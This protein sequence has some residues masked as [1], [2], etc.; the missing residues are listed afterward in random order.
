MPRLLEYLR[1]SEIFRDA[2]LLDEACQLTK[3]FMASLKTSKANT[4]RIKTLPKSKLYLS[5]YF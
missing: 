4:N 3:I 2:D 1:D 5:T